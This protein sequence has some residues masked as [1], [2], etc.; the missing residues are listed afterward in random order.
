M[1]RR[2]RGCTERDVRCAHRSMDDECK[3]SAES[4]DMERGRFGWAPAELALDTRVVEDV[5][6]QLPVERG[7][8]SGTNCTSTVSASGFEQ[9][10]RRARAYGPALIKASPFADKEVGG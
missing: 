3:P 2:V 1:K 6:D 10:N 9:A 5:A 8:R 4:L 7:R